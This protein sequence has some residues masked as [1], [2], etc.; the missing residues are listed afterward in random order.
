MAVAHRRGPEVHTYLS[1][2]GVTTQGAPQKHK[3][4]FLDADTGHAVPRKC[5]AVL[6]LGKRQSSG[7]GRDVNLYVEGAHERTR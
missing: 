3:D 4:D 5:P 7:V 6:I 2:H 1:P